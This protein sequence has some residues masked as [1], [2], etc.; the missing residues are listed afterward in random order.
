[1][2]SVS[3]GWIECQQKQQH[4]ITNLTQ[5][6]LDLESSLSFSHQKVNGLM[7]NKVLLKRP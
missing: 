3:F 2:L 4:S 6:Y 1:M 7:G 5:M